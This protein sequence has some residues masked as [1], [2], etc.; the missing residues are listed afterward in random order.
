MELKDG[1]Y[2]IITEVLIKASNLTET[3]WL[4]MEKTMLETISTGQSE[5]TSSNVFEMWNQLN[6]KVVGSMERMEKK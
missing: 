3:E 1:D 6:R 2:K 4:N 5:I